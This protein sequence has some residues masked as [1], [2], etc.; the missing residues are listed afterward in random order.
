[1]KHEAREHLNGIKE[2]KSRCDKKKTR[3]KRV[4]SKTDLINFAVSF[5]D[6]KIRNI[7]RVNSNE[8]I[9]DLNI[10]CDV[11]CSYFKTDK[12]S[13][14][15]KSRRR[16][17]VKKRQWFHYMARQFN[18]E[19]LV[20]YEYIGNYYHDVIGIKYDHAT[21]IN[22]VRKIQGYIETYNEDLLIYNDLKQL[23]LDKKN[24]EN[25]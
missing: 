24:N 20:S 17:I 12:F 1:M 9:T 10:V 21:V 25:T 3:Y 15:N 8:K 6:Y 18:I 19:H 4:F 16:D 11:V 14:I 13:I 2:Y 5:Y 22:S 7:K 23:I